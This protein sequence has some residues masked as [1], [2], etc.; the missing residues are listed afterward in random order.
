MVACAVGACSTSSST[1]AAP[2]AGQ[3]D[4]GHTD[5][6]ADLSTIMAQYKS[7]QP[8]ASAPENISSYIFALC[9]APTLNENAFS[10]SEHGKERYLL[11]WAN[12]AAVDGIQKKGAS[13][14]RGWL[15]HRQREARARSR[16]R[17]SS[18]CSRH[19]EQTRTG[20]RLDTR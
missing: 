18:G 11:D 3:A 6:M 8:Q 17:L 14:I 20:L 4:T 10:M 12:P 15:G 5:P 16:R 13:C 1:G 19:H 7:W 2:E 9:R